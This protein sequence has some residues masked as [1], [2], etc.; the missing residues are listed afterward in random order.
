MEALKVA[1][2]IISLT[3]LVVVAAGWLVGLVS[4]KASLKRLGAQV[5]GA[6]VVIDFIGII[7]ALCFGWFK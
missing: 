6:W 2:I 1:I 7:L 4:K 3:L 5:L